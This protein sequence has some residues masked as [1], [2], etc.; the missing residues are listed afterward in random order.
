MNTIYLEQYLLEANRKEGEKIKAVEYYKKT[1]ALNPNHMLARFQLGNALLMSNKSESALLEYKK[2]IKLNPDHT[3]S[4]VN[5]GHTLM[6]LGRLNQA[7]ITYEATLLKQPNISV[8][9]KNLGFIYF[10][11]KENSGKAKS[12]FQK[13][14]RLTPNQPDAAQIQSMIQSIENGKL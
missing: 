9:H 2:A 8:V 10:Q 6:K 14:L 7:R 12:H 1:L 11:M 13:Y 5:I 4:F 3:P